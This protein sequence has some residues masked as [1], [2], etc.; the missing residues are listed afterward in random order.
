MRGPTSSAASSPCTSNQILPLEG[1][2]ERLGAG[3]VFAE[4]AERA[5]AGALLPR[6][7]GAVGEGQARG[8]VER[9]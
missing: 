6:V 2:R 5:L 7:A 8:H 9:E 3:E 1:L 4:A